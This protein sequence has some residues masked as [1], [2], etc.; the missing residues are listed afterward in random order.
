M[1]V[2]VG[3]YVYVCVYVYGFMF[4][5]YVFAGFYQS[6]FSLLVIIAIIMKR[7][8][9]LSQVFNENHLHDL[10]KWMFA[11]TVFWAYTWFSQYMLIWYANMPE[12]TG[13]F[14]LR[15]NPGWENLTIALFMGKFVFPFLAL[16]PRGNKRCENLVLLVAVWILGS[17]YF[18]LSWII[19]PQF[20]PNGMRIG[21]AEIGTWL[22]FFGVFGLLLTRFL[23][24]NNVVAIKNPYLA[25]SAF[26]HHV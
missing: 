16:L 11:F 1:H 5:V 13:Y 9:Y 10:A 20:S 7:T 26:H 21:F 14:I 8:G 4:G 3:V 17:E 24:K 2:Y 23:K 15:F 18:D 19:Q 12:E 6:F 25:D 22:G